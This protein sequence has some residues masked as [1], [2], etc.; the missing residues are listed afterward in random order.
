MDDFAP[1]VYGGDEV[2]EVIASGCAVD[3]AI[4]RD[5]V[6]P[7]DVRDLLKSARS[8]DEDEY[9]PEAPGRDVVERTNIEIATDISY[10][11]LQM[12]KTAARRLKQ[13]ESDYREAQQ[14]YGEAVKRLSDE[15]VK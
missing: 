3:S 14:A 1:G 13:A 4:E 5:L 7:V 2:S 11:T 15:A 9:D 12:F 8:T 6:K 10:E